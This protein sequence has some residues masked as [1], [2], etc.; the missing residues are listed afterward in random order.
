MKKKMLPI[1]VFLL[2]FCLAACANQTSA[3]AASNASSTAV[4][5]EEHS[6]NLDAIQKELEAIAEKTSTTAT[7]AP[8]EAATEAPIP[9]VTE[10]SKE[11]NA[12][13]LFDSVMPG[14]FF[15]GGEAGL[16]DDLTEMDFVL[17]RVL[18]FLPFEF[19]V[20]QELGWTEE[21]VGTEQLDA[22]Q[23]KWFDVTKGESTI[24]VGVYNTDHTNAESISNCMVIGIEVNADDLGD[25]DFCISKGINL[26]STW[27]E[28]AEAF[29]EDE[30]AS[31]RVE[32]DTAVDFL[33]RAGSKYSVEMSFDNEDPAENT[34]TLYFDLDK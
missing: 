27:Q 14:L 25:M 3:A 20:L 32:D 15:P 1:L 34:I 5:M 26:S 9:E 10:V 23:E 16:S 13:K 17:D 24:S 21:N 4:K 8:T 11:Q 33:Y 6:T 28:V 29:G 19:S 30:Y 12:E 7:L 31:E 18:Y 22:R 2:L